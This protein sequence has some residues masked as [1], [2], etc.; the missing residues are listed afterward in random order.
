MEILSK[1]PNEFCQVL[2]HTTKTDC[3]LTKY[4]SVSKNK[5]Q[6]MVDYKDMFVYT[7]DE[8]TGDMCGTCISTATGIMAKNMI[9]IL[10]CELF[11]VKKY[12]KCWP[13]SNSF[14]IFPANIS[15]LK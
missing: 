5:F 9:P 12:L 7:V 6:Q 10:K 2:Q 13:M 14:C 4:I 8:T 1:Y 15:A 11:D 3:D